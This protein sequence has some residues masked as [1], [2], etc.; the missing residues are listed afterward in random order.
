MAI[1]TRGR[2]FLAR[3]RW[4]YWAL[5]IT[6]ATT[7]AALVQQRVAEMD[8][9]RARWTST[10]PVWVAA[11]DL[12]AD[13]DLDVR[14]TILPE[15]A[16]PPSAVTEI[17]RGAVLRHGVAAGEII[18]AGDL[19][20]A[21]VQRADTTA[22]VARLPRPMGPDLDVGGAVRVVAD[23]IVVAAR[24]RV[25]D[26]SEDVVLIAVDEVDGPIVAHAVTTGGVA[27][28]ELP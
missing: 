9:A 12:D 21:P 27:L 20:D 6:L 25:V 17:P 18:V 5:V 2:I 24:G 1:S 26:V 23:G 15:V 19:V 13:D 22:V 28:L 4:V 11:V 7:A 14:R 10:R 16:V 3:H 8:R